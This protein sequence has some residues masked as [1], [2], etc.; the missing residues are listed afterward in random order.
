[1]THFHFFSANVPIRSSPSPWWQQAAAHFSHLRKVRWLHLVLSQISWSKSGYFLSHGQNEGWSYIR[2]LI[3]RI[4][5]YTIGSLSSDAPNSLFYALPFS[6]GLSFISS[7]SQ[8]SNMFASSPFS[9]KT[10]LK[11]N[12]LK[13]ILGPYLRISLFLSIL[14]PLPLIRPTFS[15]P[16]AITSLQLA[17]QPLLLSDASS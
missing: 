16:D 17:S 9:N 11:K 1:M 6:S 14:Q 2:S 5:F 13:I 3:N 15:C 4:H 8:G 7:C 12:F 10:L